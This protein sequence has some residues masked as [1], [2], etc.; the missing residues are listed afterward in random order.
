[1]KVS[2]CVLCK[3]GSVQLS[4]SVLRGLATPD[5]HWESALLGDV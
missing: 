2:F 3:V 4:R 5:I 1:M